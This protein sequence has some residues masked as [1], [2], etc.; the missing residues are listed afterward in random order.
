M[1]VEFSE[2]KE[3]ARQV[4]AGAELPLDEKA[5]WAQ[6]V[7]LGWL[8][9]GIPEDMGGLGMGVQGACVIH[10]ELG[11][12]LSAAPYLPAM[13]AIGAL[14]E[15]EFGDR[16]TWL[17]RILG[18]ELVTASLAASH[19]ELQT[20]ASGD[21]VLNGLLSAVQSADDASHVL[22]WTAKSDALAL[23]A[24]DQAG[25][26]L[27]S[28]PTWDVTRRLFDI[29]LSGVALANQTI[30]AKGS[31]AQNIVNSLLSQR[32]FALGA[33]AVGGAAALL[34]TTV[35][36]L[37]TRRQFGRPLALFQALKHRCADI[38]AISAGAEAMLFDALARIADDSASA[39]AEHRGKAAKY[40]ATS[41]FA[42]V[43]EE[44]LQLHGGIGMAE[45]H[46][47]HLY[48]KRALLSDNLG[49]D[50]ASYDYDIAASLLD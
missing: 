38:K 40:L 18:G 20:N 46:P 24:L 5:T 17:E 13:M 48:L 23:V 47:C 1:S 49:R 2:L 50:A 31:A 19:V 14:C 3:S 33:D 29:H 32:D 22:V 12:G 26:E 6:I 41:T 15:A 44:A 21:E 34:A 42:R 7:E 36:H 30:L 25:V 9:V 10:T 11:R 16:D 4:V 27:V 35:E 45:E 37:Q 39:E 8:L 43:G 28:R